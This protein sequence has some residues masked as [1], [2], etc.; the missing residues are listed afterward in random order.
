MER[1]TVPNVAGDERAARRGTARMFESDFI[2]RFSRVH[3]LVP[4]ALYLPVVAASIYVAISRYAVPLPALAL[5]VFAGYVLW[6]FCEYWLHRLVFHLPIVGPK[7]ARL[8]FLI[9]GVHHDY[10]W[11]ETRLVFPAAASAGLCVLTYA[12]FRFAFGVDAMYGP[13][14]GFV[15]GYVIYDEMHWYVHA[16]RPTTQ[17]GR[18]L[19]REHFLH[20]FKDPTTRFG[21]SCPWLDYVFGTRPKKADGV[22]NS[23]EEERNLVSAPPD[24]GAQ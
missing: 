9:H 13:F 2:E 7:T 14:A 19:R 11:D 17:L 21:V 6:T 22:R 12:L 8:N 1:T 15:L 18:W 3:P 16:R 5:H 24:H 23:T 20:H 10:P 4:A